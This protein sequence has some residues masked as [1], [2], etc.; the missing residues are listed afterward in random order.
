MGNILKSTG[1]LLCFSSLP[2]VSMAIPVSVI[3]GIETLQQNNTCKGVVKDAQGETII[4]ASV[5][6]KGTT[7]GTITGLDGDFSLNN[8]KKGTLLRFHLLVIHL[9]KLNGMV[10]I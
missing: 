1:F 9:K 7:N 10:L 3:N 2:L 8:V 4:G 5:I 6:V